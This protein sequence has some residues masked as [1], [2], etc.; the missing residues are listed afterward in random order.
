MTLRALGTLVELYS[1]RN[2]L[3]M[4]LKTSAMLN[5]RSL[6]LSGAQKVCVS[7]GSWRGWCRNWGLGVQMGQGQGWVRVR[8]RVRVRI[9]GCCH[10][11]PLFLTDLVGSFRVRVRGERGIGIRD[12]GQG[13][14]RV[15]QGQG[16]GW[17]RVRVRVRVVV[18]SFHYF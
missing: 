14:V 4:M 10:Q 5:C 7:L 11:F 18:I 1:L 15:V 9:Q 16:Q 12:Q 3:D 2:F 17:V 8:V 6:F 13:L